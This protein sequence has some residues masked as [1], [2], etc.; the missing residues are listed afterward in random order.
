[1]SSKHK[2]VQ[3]LARFSEMSDLSI[4]ELKESF[5]LS[6]SGREGAK[7]ICL[8]GPKMK[9]K[10]YTHLIVSGWG[11][12]NYTDDGSEVECEDEETPGGRG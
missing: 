12:H 4:L 1:M 2:S 6:N 10:P 11:A 8:P 9:L 5:D 3:E 7:A